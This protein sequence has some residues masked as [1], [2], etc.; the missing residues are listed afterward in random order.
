[1]GIIQKLDHRVQGQVYGRVIPHLNLEDKVD[2]PGGEN[3]SEES[4]MR[5]NP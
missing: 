5:D 4:V 3:V 2:L 1:L